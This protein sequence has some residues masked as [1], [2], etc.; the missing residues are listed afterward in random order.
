M[1]D[2]RNRER[3]DLISLFHPRRSTISSSG[4]GAAASAP[5]RTASATHLSERVRARR[6]ELQLRELDIDCPD[7]EDQAVT[8]ICNGRG[9]ILAMRAFVRPEDSA[10]RGSGCAAP[11]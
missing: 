10:P 1:F 6:A 8:M 7:V 5:R 3:L 9:R 4:A 2:P 11:L